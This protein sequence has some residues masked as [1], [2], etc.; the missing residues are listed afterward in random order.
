[1]NVEC[2]IAFMK[3]FFVMIT[4]KFQHSTFGIAILWAKISCLMPFIIP[5][6]LGR[7][8][9]RNPESGTGAGAG[10]G[11]GNGNGTGTGTGTET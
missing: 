10:N 11:N 2:T 1:M 7:M 6:I 9:N 8:E 5:Y 4:T 3:V